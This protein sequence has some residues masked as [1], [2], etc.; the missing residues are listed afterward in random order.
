MFSIQECMER[1]ILKFPAARSLDE[2]KRALEEF[3]AD[4]GFAHGS[5]YLPAQPQWANADRIIMLT[6]PQPWIDHYF[7]S[8]YYLIDPV[9]SEGMGGLLPTDWSTF[10]TR[11]PK[12]RTLFQEAKENGVG[13]QGLTIAIRGPSL[14]TAIFSVTSNVSDRD[15]R[16]TRRTM[17]ASLQ[18]IGQ[19]FHEKIMTLTGRRCTQLQPSLSPRELDCIRYCAMGL[20]DREAAESMGISEGVARAYLDSARRKLQAPT[21]PNAVARAFGL[22]I[23][24]S[25]IL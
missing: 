10:D 17:T 13:S 1:A 11:P 21:R 18:L 6:Y 25:N 2:L 23:I 16:E 5:Y 19:M 24:S 8:Q 14:E 22:G 3:V 20:R 15:W 7:E 4:A 9:I 12:I